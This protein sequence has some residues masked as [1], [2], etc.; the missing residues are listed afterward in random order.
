MDANE[1]ESAK[2]KNPELVNNI[3][4]GIIIKGYLKVV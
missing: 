4:N 2:K 3:S 1:F